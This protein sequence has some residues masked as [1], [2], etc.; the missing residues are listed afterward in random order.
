MTQ[1]EEKSLPVRLP[2]DIHQLFKIEAA[3][4]GRSMVKMVREWVENYLKQKGK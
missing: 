1:R 3:K 4:E 2:K